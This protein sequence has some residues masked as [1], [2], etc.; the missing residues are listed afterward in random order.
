MHDLAD[1]TNFN[2][3]G[4]KGA[5]SVQ[6]S[7]KTVFSHGINNYLCSDHHCESCDWVQSSKLEQIMWLCGRWDISVESL[8]FI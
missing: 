7:V 6:P 5:A 4:L 2:L 8:C 1:V 3:R